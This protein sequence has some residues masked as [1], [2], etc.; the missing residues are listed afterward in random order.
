MKHWFFEALNRLH[1]QAATS[2][3]FTGHQRRLRAPDEHC[4]AAALEQLSASAPA[5]SADRGRGMNRAGAHITFQN[6][7][8]ARRISNDGNP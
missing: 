4:S 1:V 5:I 8:E 3:D 6:Q 2:L 7:S